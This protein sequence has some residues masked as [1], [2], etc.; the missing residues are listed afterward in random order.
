MR[1][2]K[3]EKVTAKKGKSG[4]GRGIEA[5][6]EREGRGGKEKRRRKGKEG[7]EGRGERKGGGREG[8]HE[9]E[10]D[11]K[12]HCTGTCLWEH[13]AEPLKMSSCIYRT[14]ILNGVTATE[15]ST[16][17]AKLK[18]CIQ[19]SLLWVLKIISL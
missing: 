14:F 6:R 7:G 4:K 12:K 19:L 18:D 1:A 17:C 2:A 15:P 16:E 13:A 10:V 5:K 9:E 8:S 3:K 11:K